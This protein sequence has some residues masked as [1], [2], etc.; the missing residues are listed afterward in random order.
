MAEPRTNRAPRI[1]GEIAII[2]AGVLIALGAEEFR[3]GAAER[4]LIDSYLV[5]LATDLRG[6]SVEFAGML[7]PA[8]LPAQRDATLRLIAILSEPDS[9]PSDVRVLSYLRAQVNLPSTRKRRATF[10]DLIGSGRL[11][12]IE[13]PDLRRGLV[14]Y[15]ASSVA[16]D[17]SAYDAYLHTSF[18]PFTHHLTVAL[19]PGRYH[20]MASC[21][22]LL[23]ADPE[24]EAC[25][26]AASMG[27]ELDLL[28]ND[29]ELGALVV[30]QIMQHFLALNGVQT[31]QRQVLALL[32]QLD[33]R[34]L[35]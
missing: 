27:N 30:D 25:Y 11:G 16:T 22:V 29:P 9:T 26:E 31:A 1:L 34:G 5:S 7:Q 8:R 32:S 12:L 10:E 4:R 23:E 28:R 6:D 20:A 2:V 14:E 13:D 33:E 19:G 3:E 24:V 18:F 21:P 15:Y 17:Q 35:E